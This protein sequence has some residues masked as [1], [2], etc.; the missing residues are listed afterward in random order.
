MNPAPGYKG[1]FRVEELGRQEKPRR[2]PGAV[3][4]EPGQREAGPEQAPRLAANADWN[5]GVAVGEADARSL[6]TRCHW[7]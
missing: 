4:Q 6:L 5:G 7:L 3:W 2:W 1:A